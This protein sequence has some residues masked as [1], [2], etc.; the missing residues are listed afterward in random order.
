[1]A[2]IHYHEKLVVLPAFFLNKLTDRIRR[3]L[4]VEVI[5]GPLTRFPELNLSTSSIPDH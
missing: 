5:P 2:G 4:P 1:M 3:F